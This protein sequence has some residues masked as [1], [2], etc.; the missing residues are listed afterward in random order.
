MCHY[1]VRTESPEPEHREMLMAEIPNALTDLV[2]RKT[3]DEVY[4]TL[5]DA[6]CLSSNGIEQ[7]TQVL[8]LIA[9]ADAEALVHR[10]RGMVGGTREC[11]IV[12]ALMH[13]AC[14]NARARA[15]LDTITYRARP[16]AP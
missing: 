16:D 1:P 11:Y 12:G 7:R 6:H 5:R 15:L 3:P 14:L 13:G 9:E 10:Q 4:E 8:A 2:R